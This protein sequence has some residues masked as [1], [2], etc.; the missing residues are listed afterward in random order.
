VVPLR[1]GRAIF[2]SAATAFAVAAS[3]AA[4][5]LG[6]WAASLHHSLSNARAAN[7]VLGDPSSRHIAVQG[8]KGE[9]VVAP[10]GAAVLAVHLPSPPKGKTYEAWVANPNVQ[11]AGEFDGQTT[12]LPVRV[13]R[14][15]Q[16]MVTI[17]RDGGVDAPTMHPLLIA[18]A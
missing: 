12:K 14:G 18:R 8:A 2:A 16:V 1:P 6:I 7:R 3:A 17:E 5:G 10:S 4:V 11:R 9:L 13:T 15:A